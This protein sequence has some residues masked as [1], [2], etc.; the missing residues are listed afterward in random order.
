M[1]YRLHVIQS[2]AELTDCLNHKLSVTSSLVEPVSC[3]PSL[4]PYLS[5][6][7]AAQVSELIY[8]YLGMKYMREKD[9]Y[10]IVI[11]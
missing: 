1:A 11:V 4:T 8:H 2:V 3:A 10:H 5:W 7:L 9:W 6:K